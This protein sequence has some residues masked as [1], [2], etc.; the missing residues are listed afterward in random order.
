ML[1]NA[2]HHITNKCAHLIISGL[3]STNLK[4]YLTNIRLRKVWT[5]N[6]V[7]EDIRYVLTLEIDICLTR[8]EK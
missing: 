3:P 7:L 5:Y 4:C 8:K 2:N 6:V 1:L